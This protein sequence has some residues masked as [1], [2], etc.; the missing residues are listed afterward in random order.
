MQTWEVGQALGPYP[1][2]PGYIG[3]LQYGFLNQTFNGTHLSCNNGK[4][5]DTGRE[6]HGVTPAERNVRV[7]MRKNGTNITD[8]SELEA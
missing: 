6:F 2:K 3:V 1:V 8:T 7:S 4:W 5:E